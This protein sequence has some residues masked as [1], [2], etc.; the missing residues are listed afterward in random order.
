LSSF[1]ALQQVTSGDSLFENLGAQGPSERYGTNRPA[2][3]LS[4]LVLT[5]MP[6]AN[7]EHVLCI[8]GN[9]STGAQKQAEG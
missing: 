1:Q 7:D 6:Q 3:R 2:R 5:D 8:S 4:V 9:G